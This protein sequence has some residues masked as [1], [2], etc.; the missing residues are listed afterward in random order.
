[1]LSFEP[2]YLKIDLPYIRGIESNHRHQTIVNAIV[3]LAHGNGIMV[4]AEGVETE[5][6]QKVLESLG[7]D[8]SQG[9]LFSKPKAGI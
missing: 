2:N 4:I 6:E 3:V 5:A 8:F 1:M 9:Y 7:V